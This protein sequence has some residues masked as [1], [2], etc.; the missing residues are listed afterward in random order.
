MR[1]ASL[2]R[3]VLMA[4]IT[5]RNLWITWLERRQTCAGR[6]DGYGQVLATI[7]L[8][9][10][11][12]GCADPIWS[13]HSQ[14]QVSLRVA[15]AALA[16]GAP[17]LALRVADLAL[18]HEPRSLMALIAR[19][20]ALYAMGDR[21]SAQASYRVAVAIEPAAVGAQ[22]GLGRTLIQM[23]PGA[24]ATAFQAAI[25]Q[26]PSN[27]PAL[28]NLGVANDL[29]GRHAEAQDAYH[30]ALMI[31]PATS[32]VKVNLGLSLALSDRKDDADR[33]LRAVAA[34][35][36]AAVAFRAELAGALVVAGDESA[37]RQVLN[38]TV[39]QP[40]PNTHSTV[41]L[42]GDPR[43]YPTHPPPANRKRPNETMPQYALTTARQPSIME[44]SGDVSSQSVRN[45]AAIYPQT[46]RHD[47]V[48]R[49]TASATGT[50]DTTA[51]SICS[52][53]LAGSRRVRALPTATP[54]QI[55]AQSAQRM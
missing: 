29:Q 18:A 20:D 13:R 4:L 44:H 27:V 54:Q 1:S 9:L 30:R 14:P 28:S 51:A 37:A 32:D 26:D 17:E 34:E 15:N 36:G 16:A 50:R 39:D 33:L 3:A 48:R 23:E 49:R 47:R 2:Q 11:L 6:T 7:A 24:A 43:P 41:D 42:A 40:G 55:A 19:G 22:L 52:T 35:P 46:G 38:R 21:E 31:A 12:T 10:L 8:A 53:C 25:D 5:A 45:H